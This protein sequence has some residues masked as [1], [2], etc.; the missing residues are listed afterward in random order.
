MTLQS[1]LE[2][3]LPFLRAEA[4]ARMTSI[5]RVRR[6]TGRLA[7]DPD[8]GREAPVWST[9]H[10]ELPAK[11]RTNRGGDGASSSSTEGGVTTVRGRRELHVPY[12]TR[13]L[14][15]DDLVEFTSGEW[16]DSVWRIV[17]ASPGGDQATARRLPVVEVTRPTEWG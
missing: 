6:T 11:L 10:D 2:A 8:T 5:I 3:E 13:D 16:E 12:G 1:A 7:Q 17:D 4:T 14:R 9:P 15:D